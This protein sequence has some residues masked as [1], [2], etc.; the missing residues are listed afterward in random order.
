MVFT[1]GCTILGMWYHVHLP[2]PPHTIQDN[3]NVSMTFI[4]K[5]TISQYSHFT[6][7]KKNTKWQKPFMIPTR[8]RSYFDP[9]VMSKNGQ[10]NKYHTRHISSTYKALKQFFAICRFKWY[11]FWTKLSSI[12]IYVFSSPISSLNWHELK[13][14]S[15]K[16][17]TPVLR[18]PWL[19]CTVDEY[20]LMHVRASDPERLSSFSLLWCSDLSVWALP[21]HCRLNCT[22]CGDAGDKKTGKMVPINWMPSF[23]TVPQRDKTGDRGRPTL[24][25]SKQLTWVAERRSW[26]DVIILIRQC[27]FLGYL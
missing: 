13:V 14:C 7:Q 15:L 4:C 23:A 26:L 2:Q 3:V 22:S 9:S 11:V 8:N 17:T 19:Y 18:N 5:A 25:Y 10:V 6:C 12:Q 1:H 16:P 21:R 20:L 24:F 27:C